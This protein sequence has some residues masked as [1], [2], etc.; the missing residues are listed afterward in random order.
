MTSQTAFLLVLH[1]EV[2]GGRSFHQMPNLNKFDVLRLTLPSR[3]GLKPAGFGTRQDIRAT[4][5]RR[6]LVES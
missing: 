6:Q 3:P 2:G 1:L 5:N 4:G